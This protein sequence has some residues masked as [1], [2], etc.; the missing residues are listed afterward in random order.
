MD[1]DNL[2]F[3]TP[4]PPVADGFGVAVSAATVGGVLRRTN[5]K[6]GPKIVVEFLAMVYMRNKVTKIVVC[7]V[8]R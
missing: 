7:S 3:F 5:S 6:S 2:T 1:A 8:I 4:D